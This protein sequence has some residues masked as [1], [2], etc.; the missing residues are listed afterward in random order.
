MVEGSAYVA[1][2]LG[3]MTLAQMGADVIRFDP[4]G[5]GLDRTRWP[6]N[7]EGTSLFW[8]GLNKGKRSI[9]VDLR[10][11]RGQEV[12]TEL[13][14]APGPGRRD[15]AHEL[16]PPGLARLRAARRAAPGPDHGQHRRQPRRLVGGRLHRQPVDR[17]PVGDRAAPPLG[18]L[19]PPAP[20]LGRDHR[21]PRGR[22]GARRRAPPG[23]HGR[24]PAGAGRA[25]R[26]RLRDGRQ[27]GQ[28]RRGAGA[29]ARAAQGR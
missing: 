21:H 6:V 2:P 22:R 19:Q 10:S 15:R 13:I 11:E 1:A 17:I 7:E 8:A 28:D 12:L 3:G 5:G 25:L 24:G 20:G 23:A 4:I 18:A 27:P 29:A 26:R 14:T 16:P 9:Q